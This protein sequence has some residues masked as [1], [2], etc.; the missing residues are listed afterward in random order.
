MVL[1]VA[2]AAKRAPML[3]FEFHGVLFQLALREPEL[4][5][6]FQ[7]PPRMTAIPSSP[8]YFG[9]FFCSCSRLIQLP[10]IAPTSAISA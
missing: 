5:P 4:A 10:S 7:L 6:L 8:L 2:T 9:T 3:L 1:A